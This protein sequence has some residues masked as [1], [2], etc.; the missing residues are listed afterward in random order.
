MVVLRELAKVVLIWIK[1][2]LYLGRI[3]PVL[4]IVFLKRASHVASV[5]IALMAAQPLKGRRVCVCVLG[6]IGRS[7]R[8]QYHALSLLSEGAELSLVAYEGENLVPPLESKKESIDLAL[9]TPFEWPALKRACWPAFAA[10]KAACLV[11]QLFWALLSG[12]HS[13][14][15]LVL[16]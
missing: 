15:C 1:S 14:T 7:P 10:V 6:D 12:H 13:L 8:M 4:Y 3:L 16:P 9:F 2:S 11:V 5:A